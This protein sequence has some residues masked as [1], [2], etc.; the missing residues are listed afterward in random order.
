[1]KFWGTAGLPGSRTAASSNAVRTTTPAGP[2]VYATASK[3][4]PMLGAKGARPPLTLRRLPPSELR[5][6]RAVIRVAS[7]QAL[8]RAQQDG[9]RAFEI[10]GAEDQHAQILA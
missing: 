1:M 5:L 2:W 4:Q 10:I 9:Q 8:R 6:A 3:P 7:L